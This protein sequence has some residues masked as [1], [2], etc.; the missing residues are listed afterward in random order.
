MRETAYKCYFTL[1]VTAALSGGMVAGFLTDKAWAGI[2]VWSM[3]FGSLS[4]LH[5]AA[6]EIIDAIASTTKK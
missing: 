2:G 3:I 1:A 4:A 6:C 5:I